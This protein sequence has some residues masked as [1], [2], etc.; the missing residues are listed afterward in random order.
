MAKKGSD[1]S[2]V[3]D[4]AK[5]RVLF[6]EVEGNNES[7]Q[8]ALR[9]MISAM[10]RPAQITQQQV[11][12][13]HAS[14][15]IEQSPAEQE[16]PSETDDADETQTATHTKVSRPSR[17]GKKT[18]RNSGVKMVHDLNF[19]PQD[20]EPLKDFI[21]GK[22]PKTDLELV[23]ALVYYMKNIMSE[24]K[25]GLDHI[26]TAL[27]EVGKPVPAALKQTV[28]NLKTKKAWINYT[29]IE[30]IRTT[31]QGDNFVEHEMTKGE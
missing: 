13:A 17:A 20:N 28:Q 1:P 9:T 23:L 24:S 12:N 15:Q 2:T 3:G 11:P 6:A 29:D 31:T 26:L 19:R 18:D 25:V 16:S 27:K 4:K 8:Q 30:D 14:F 10:A 21:S 22:D 5:I 7:V